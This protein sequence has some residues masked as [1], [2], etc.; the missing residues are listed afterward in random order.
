MNFEELIDLTTA[1][2]KYLI[3]TVPIAVAITG[4]I[5]GMVYI[6]IGAYIP[7]GAS[8]IASAACLYIRRIYIK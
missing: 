3:M 5:A 8:L 1:F 6:F 7:A 4:M 2:L